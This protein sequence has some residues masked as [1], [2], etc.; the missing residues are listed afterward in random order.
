MLTHTPVDTKTNKIKLKKSGTCDFV[1]E[2][3]TNQR[4]SLKTKKMY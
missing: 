4:V 1:R 2:K 3:Y